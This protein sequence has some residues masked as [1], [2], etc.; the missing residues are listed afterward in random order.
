MGNFVRGRNESLGD[1]NRGKVSSKQLDKYNRVVYYGRVFKI[2]DDNNMKLKVFIRGVDPNDANNDTLP[3]C[4]PF[5]PRMFNVVPKVGETVKILL[6]DTKNPT[7]EREWIGPIISQPE[8]IGEDPHFFTSLAGKVGG[9]MKLGR[10]IKTIP[11]ADGVYPK[12]DDVCMLGRDNSDVVLRS[13][14]V[15]IRAGKHEL[16]TPLKLNRKNPAYLNMVVLKPSDIEDDKFTE[17]RTDTILMSNKIFLVGRDSNSKVINPIISKK[18]HLQLEKDL[19]P[20]VYGDVLYDFMVILRQWIKSHI[21]EG[22]GVAATPPDRSGA[23]VKLED[24]FIKNLDDRLL[25][26]NV[27]VGGDVPVEDGSGPQRD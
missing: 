22:G 20:I 12:E 2:S 13:N 15:L 26:Q 6:M 11:E 27:F 23:T 1:G 10:S 14:E 17:D 24:W 19:H 7:I 25:S 18:E 16:D 21:H 8:K 5:L 3:W 9:L 4:E